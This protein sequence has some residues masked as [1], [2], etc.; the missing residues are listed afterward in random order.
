MKV[1]TLHKSISEEEILVTLIF[2]EWDEASIVRQIIKII[3]NSRLPQELVTR[4]FTQPHL[5]CTRKVILGL[6]SLFRTSS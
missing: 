6:R 5:G 1:K 3:V 2:E 4:P